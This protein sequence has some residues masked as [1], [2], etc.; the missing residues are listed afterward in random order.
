MGG[1]IGAQIK[2]LAFGG[3]FGRQ[4]LEGQEEGDSSD[5]CGQSSPGL[6]CGESPRGWEGLESG[7]RQSGEWT[8]RCPGVGHWWFGFRWWV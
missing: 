8:A 4:T 3:K 5:L 7:A 6:L 2:S 1:R